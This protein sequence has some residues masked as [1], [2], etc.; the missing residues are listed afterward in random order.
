MALELTGVRFTRHLHLV[1]RSHSASLQ[2]HEGNSL[3]LSARI[4]PGLLSRVE[5]SWIMAIRAA[6]DGRGVD[7]SSKWQMNGLT[8]DDCF[9]GPKS[10]EHVE[11]PSRLSVAVPVT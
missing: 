11:Q 9:A 2:A 4:P 7:H 8:N 5:N 1:L 6:V 3:P 10:R